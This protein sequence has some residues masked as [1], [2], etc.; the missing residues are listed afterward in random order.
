MVFTLANFPD[1]GVPD[2][3][4]KSCSCN[5]GRLL[6]F[7]LDFSA[8]ASLSHV[9]QGDLTASFDC[10]GLLWGVASCRATLGGNHALEQQLLTLSV[11]ASCE[12]FF[13]NK[14]SHLTTLTPS[15]PPMLSQRDIAASPASLPVRLIA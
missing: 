1:I 4:A 10:A 8:L 14:Q 13:T 11:Y 7:V 6:R 3:W 5:V 9:H 2:T 15:P 12:N